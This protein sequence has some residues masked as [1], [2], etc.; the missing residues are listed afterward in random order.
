MKLPMKSSGAGFT[1]IELIITISIIAILAAIA[2]PNY[3][4][5]VIRSNRSVARG[6]LV[7]L[8]AK[9]EVLKLQNTVYSTDFTYLAGVSG[10]SYYINRSS[11]V[12]ATQMP[13]SIYQISLNPA[14]STAFTLTATPVTGSPQAKDTQCTS[15]I[16]ASTGLRTA[17]G[18][19]PTLCWSK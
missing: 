2:F 5:Y 7:D 9:Q 3:T 16:L 11:L 19:S 18:S 6:V 15:L 12:E 10:T 4:S 1:L 13:D 8:A 14:T 17:T